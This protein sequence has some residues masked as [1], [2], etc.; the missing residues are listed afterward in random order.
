[1]NERPR[2]VLGQLLARY[3]EGLVDEPKRVDALLRDLCPKLQREN[4]ALVTAAQAGVPGELKSGVKHESV[5]VLTARL[6]K[7]LSQSYGLSTAVAIWAVE[8]WALALKLAST[9]EVRIVAKCPACEAP[10]HAAKHLL[11][12]RVK[13]PKCQAEMT[14]G[15]GSLTAAPTSVNVPQIASNLRAQTT[16]SIPTNQQKSTPTNSLSSQSN[17]AEY[18]VWS[19]GQPTGPYSLEYLINQPMPMSVEVWRKGL[20]GWTRPELIPELKQMALVLEEE[21]ERIVV[22]VKPTARSI[23]AIHSVSKSSSSSAGESA[24]TNQGTRLEPHRGAL[25]VAL[26]ASGIILC[27]TPLGIAA[28]IMG[29]VDLVAMEKGKM[30]SS[31]RD[32]TVAG[33]ILGAFGT[34]LFLII[35]GLTAGIG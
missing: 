20:P 29:M 32:L 2:L 30:D 6:A 34:A 5:Q 3:G 7:R 9:D 35:I 33:L 28:L 15:V 14:V 16:D 8:S 12:K 19:N 23:P 10:V 11:G 24:V 1:M 22:D 17:T 13:C 31:G 26:G 4:F 25:V 27:F 21:T 18:Y